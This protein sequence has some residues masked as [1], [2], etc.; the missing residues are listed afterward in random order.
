MKRGKKIVVFAML[1]LQMY[2]FFF[3]SLHYLNGRGS[4]REE[5]GA[6]ER[7]KCSIIGVFCSRLASESVLNGTVTESRH[8]N[9][10]CIY[11]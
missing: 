6:K 5:Q 10:L 11:V 8:A 4:E 3:L 9:C 2:V 7:G 1:R